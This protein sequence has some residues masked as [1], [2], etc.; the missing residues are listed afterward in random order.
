[1]FPLPIVEYLHL[2]CA[3]VYVAALMAGHWNV[4]AARR[5]PTWAERAPLFELNRR[6]ALMFSLPALI[7]TGIIGN[8]LAMEMG[9]SMGH[10]RP[11]QI[12]TALWVI[13]LALALAL[14][15]P[16]AARLATQA[17]AAAGANRGEPVEWDASLGRWRL[18][19]ALQL[20][21]F[22]VL[23]WFMVQAWKA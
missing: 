11:L 22:F 4:L 14:D 10:A 2:L 17:R 12:V 5:A 21:V 8:L 3:F 16:L 9:L 1:M 15:V 6:V 18:G 7:L 23:L 20:L 19:N 13:L